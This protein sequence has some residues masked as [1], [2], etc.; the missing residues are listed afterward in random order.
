MSI[1]TRRG[2]EYIFLDF[3]FGAH[4]L[5]TS[6]LFVMANNAMFNIENEYLYIISDTKDLL[7]LII[8]NS[9]RRTKSMFTLECVLCIMAMKKSHLCSHERSFRFA[10]FCLAD[11]LPS[12][13]GGLGFKSGGCMCVFRF[14]IRLLRR[15]G[16]FNEWESKI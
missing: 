11:T 6:I 5:T 9:F 13:I 12:W 2:T 14:R 16:S 8:L 4:C 7:V 15:N 1:N 10:R 3:A